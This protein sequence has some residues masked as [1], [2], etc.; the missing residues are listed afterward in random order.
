RHHPP[1]VDG[2]VGGAA[3][4]RAGKGLAVGAGE[5]RRLAQSS[6]EA[7]TEIKQL[8]EQSVNEVKGGTQLVAGA[9]DKLNVLLE[10]ARD[11]ERLMASIAQESAAQASAIEEVNV[12]VRQMDEMTQHNAA[13]V[14]EINAAIEQA[15]SQAI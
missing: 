3:G 1:G 13:L 15:E 4:R 5:V 12:A 9:A 11:S 2:A 6:A 8:I 10:G 7:S 14:E